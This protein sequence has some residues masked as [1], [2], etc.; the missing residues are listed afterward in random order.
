MFLE[1]GGGHDGDNTFLTG[2]D[3]SARSGKKNSISCDQ[4]AARI[5]GK[6]TRIP[7]LELSERRGTGLRRAGPE[8]PRLV[9]GRRAARRRVRS[10]RRCSIGCSAPTPPNERRESERRFR[11][12]RSLLDGMRDQARQL[13]QAVGRADRERLE[14]YFTSLREVEKQLEREVIVVENPK[15]RLAA[16]RRGDV[17][18]SMHPE[19]PNFDY[20]IYARLMYDLIALAW[21]TDSTRV[22]T[23]VVRREL[24]SHYPGIESSTDYHNLTHHGGDAK[25]LDELARIDTIYMQHLAVL[26]QAEVDQGGGRHVA[27]SLPHRRRQRHGHGPQPQ[28]A[29]HAGGRRQKARAPPPRVREVRQRHAAREPVVHHAGERGC[30]RR[31]ATPRSH[32]PAPRAAVILRGEARSL[33]PRHAEGSPPPRQ[34]AAR[35]GTPLRGRAAFLAATGILLAAAPAGAAAGPAARL[36]DGAGI[37]L[38]LIPAGEFLM[39]AA[40][41]QGEALQVRFWRSAAPDERDLLSEKPSHRVRITR[42]FYLGAH[43]VTVGQFRRFVTATGYKTDA[44]KGGRG[45][46]GFDPKPGPGRKSGQFET[47]AKYSWRNPGFPQGDDHPVV[48][49]SWNDATAFAA[50]LSRDQKATYRLPT[51]AEWEYACRAGTESWLDFG[52]DPSVAH[53]HANLADATLES[54]QPGHVSRQRLIDPAKDPRDGFAYTAP[55]GRFKPN[56]FGLYDMHGNVWEWCQ[57][58]YSATAYQE[59]DPKAVAVDP[60][61]P[62]AGIPGRRFSSAPRWV[63]VRRR[64]DRALVVAAPGRRVRLVLLCGVSPGPRT[65]TPKKS[66]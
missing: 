60:Q 53:L 35:P 34:P 65:L 46:R 55:V 44:E 15:P 22:V 10:R 14:Q 58:R 28:P 38:V 11:Q 39:G 45:A 12:R 13:E 41:K 24:F 29:A 54:A 23:Y 26:R 59:L 16:R 8:H 31:S 3:T 25:K 51:E 9:R 18:V 40:D 17:R 49:V 37:D 32:W 61:G 20:R 66:R 42:T 63:M 64:R 19:T 43:E 62:K 21:Q 30:A 33:R 50:W 2:A 1:F 56:A 48:A 6:T 27:R 47:S 57:D 36:T 5:L 7:S 52:D 4:V